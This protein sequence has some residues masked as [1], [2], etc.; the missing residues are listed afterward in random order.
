MVVKFR[1]FEERQTL[2]LSDVTTVGA[3]WAMQCNAMMKSLTEIR[4]LSYFIVNIC[5][6]SFIRAV[7]DKQMW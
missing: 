1:G 4:I 2:W 6:Y 3:A 5:V 7:A